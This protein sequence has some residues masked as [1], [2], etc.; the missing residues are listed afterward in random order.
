M[1]LSMES[2]KNLKNQISINNTW[3]K[4]K[5]WYNHFK[6]TFFKYNY[7][8]LSILLNFITFIFN[9]K[10]EGDNFMSVIISA[11][12][13]FISWFVSFSAASKKYY[14]LSKKTKAQSHKSD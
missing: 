1:I 6:A 8:V 12:F 5:I 7:I 2:H 14:F 4:N 9:I 13:L 10:A 3:K 11:I